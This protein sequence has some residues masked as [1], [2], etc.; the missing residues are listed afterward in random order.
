MHRPRNNVPLTTPCV[1]WQWFLR[2][3]ESSRWEERKAEKG[4][5]EAG[6]RYSAR[7]IR[8]ASPLFLPE[9]LGAAERD[10]ARSRDARENHGLFVVIYRRLFHTFYFFP[11]ATRYYFG[12]RYPPLPLAGII[13]DLRSEEIPALRERNREDR[14]RDVGSTGSETLL[15]TVQQNYLI[16]S[17]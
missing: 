6:L 3:A 7:S 2:I 17:L 15:A 16:S 8:I 4:R 10:K 1:I 9:T 11:A 13:D 5:A 14:E 12:R